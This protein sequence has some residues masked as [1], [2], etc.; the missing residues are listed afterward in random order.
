MIKYY[1]STGEFHIGG[2]P[3][4]QGYAGKK[5][6]YRNNPEAQHEKD[7][8]PLPRGRY[9]MVYIG[10]QQ[11]KDKGKYIIRLIPMLGNEM[12]GRD[13]FLIHGG[14]EDASTGCIILQLWQRQFIIER[15]KAHD[16]ILEVVR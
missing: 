15:I 10:S 12:H 5:G 14:K 4:L 2:G 11:Y 7:K 1:Q 8:G 13:G 6:V 9:K 3:V 16:D